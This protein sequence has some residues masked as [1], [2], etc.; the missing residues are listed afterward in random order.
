MQK[1]C[2]DFLNRDKLF[3]IELFHFYPPLM[4][5]LFP[6]T[7]FVKVKKTAFLL[8]LTFYR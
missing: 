3:L 8:F 4:L 7:I 1:N 2:L 6:L 5:S